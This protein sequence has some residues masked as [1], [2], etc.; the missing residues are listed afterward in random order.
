[1]IST[2]T[3]YKTE[4]DYYS[5]FTEPCGLRTMKQEPNPASSRDIICLFPYFPRKETIFEADDVAVSPQRA[6]QPDGLGL[7]PKD[8]VV[9]IFT[10]DAAHLSSP[11]TGACGSWMDPQHLENASLFEKLW[12]PLG[13]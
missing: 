2:I 11:H 4:L 12:L 13:R 7:Y 8:G 9:G 5:M 6:Q 1:M 3:E 10:G